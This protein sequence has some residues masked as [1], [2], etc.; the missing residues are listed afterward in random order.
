MSRGR[1]WSYLSYNLARFGIPSDVVEDVSG[2]YEFDPW[3][4]EPKA[5][6]VLVTLSLEAATRLSEMLD[7]LYEG[8]APLAEPNP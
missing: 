2:D 7:D 5:E 6:V 1:D 8:Q 4:P 3:R